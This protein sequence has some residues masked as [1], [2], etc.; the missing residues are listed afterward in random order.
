MTALSSD[1]NHQ[2]QSYWYT[3][4][5]FQS[6]LTV[7]SRSEI[8]KKRQEREMER[9]GIDCRRRCDGRN[10]RRSE[11]KTKKLANH[12]LQRWRIIVIFLNMC[13]KMY[14]LSRI[15]FF[16]T[17][18]LTRHRKKSNKKSFPNTRLS[19]QFVGF[20][21]FICLTCQ[22]YWARVGVTLDVKAVQRWL[23]SS[24]LRLP[25][26]L[27]A[28]LTTWTTH[29]QGTTTLVWARWQKRRHTK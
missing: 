15:R 19:F 9:I 22:A 8:L 11:K 23:D 17:R 14:R 4:F 25:T 29:R 13:V 1:R 10:G 26:R 16:E 21:F 24:R 27:L 20:L 6:A 2:P 3:Y 7:S 18:S 12:I 5:G 28:L